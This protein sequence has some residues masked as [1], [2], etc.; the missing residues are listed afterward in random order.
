[1]WIVN[2]KGNRIVDIV[3]GK[4]IF[5]NEYKGKFNVSTEFVFNGKE[6]LEC[7]KS[8][9][10]EENAKTYLE[11]LCDRLNLAHYKLPAR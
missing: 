3:T 9:T 4:Y 1:M 7:L 6:S 11:G 10:K 5:Y 2:N 8:F